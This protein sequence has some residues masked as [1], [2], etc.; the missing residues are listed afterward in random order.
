MTRKAFVSILIHFRVFVPFLD[1]VHA[2]G[3]KTQ[4][5]QRICDSVYE[6]ISEA[7][8]IEQNKAF[9]MQHGALRKYFTKHSSEVCYNVR[10]MERNERNRGSSWSL[11]QTGVYQR[12][13]TIKQS[14][15]WILLQPSDYM[16]RR[17]SETLRHDSNFHYDNSIGPLH[18]HGLFLSASERNWSD[19]IEHTQREIESLVS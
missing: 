7:Q 13:D 18:L 10:Y 16:R 15:V 1:L 9:G 6:H 3:R 19:Y 12:Y 5:D 2:F 8:G 17:L 11:R 4:E 14:S